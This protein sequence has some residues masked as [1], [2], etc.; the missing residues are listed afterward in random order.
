MH[1]DDDKA[2]VVTYNEHV[3]KILSERYFNS[4][5]R[6]HTGDVKDRLDVYY[7]PL[8]ISATSQD[9]EKMKPED[10]D[11]CE[12]VPESVDGV[13]AAPGTAQAT[14][15]TPLELSLVSRCIAHQKREIAARSRLPSWTDDSLTSASLWI[16]DWSLNRRNTFKHFLIVADSGEEYYEPG[17]FLYVWFDFLPWR[18]IEMHSD[19][20][21]VGNVVLPT[22]KP[23]KVVVR[24][25]KG[26]ENLRR[27][28]CD[29]TINFR[30]QEFMSQRHVER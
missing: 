10:V 16:N 22:E 21:D 13:L 12:S 7:L 6:N 24:R 3:T 23:P 1:R 30:W 18:W 29:V 11:F 2:R 14:S 26:T 5:H 19:E 28:L 4:S 27:N 9:N 20:D 15:I 17:G 8:P 25:V